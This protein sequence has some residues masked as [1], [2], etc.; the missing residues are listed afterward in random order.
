MARLT[1]TEEGGGIVVVTLDRAEAM[2]A[3]DTQMAREMLELFGNVRRRRDDLRCVVLAAAGG[4]AFSVGADLKERDGMSVEDWRRQHALFRDAYD[5]LWRFP[6]PIVAAVEGY[7]LGGGCELALACDFIIASETASFA[8]PE[9]RL[10][11]MPGCGG[12]QLLPRA[13]PE[14]VARELIFTGR[15]FGAAE[16]QAWGMVNRVV[17]PGGALAEALE[18]ARAIAANAPL[19]IQG[20]KRA[21]DHGL[22][23]DLSTALALEVSIHQRLS[24]SDDRMEGIAAFNGKRAPRWRNQ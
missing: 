14:R 10:G 12:T 8:L 15:R 18:S 22:Q 9:I 21:I 23:T 19:A 24:A 17:A 11:I 4:K 16:A 6:W 13:M 7:A 3:F 2:N 20:A 1:S 5:T